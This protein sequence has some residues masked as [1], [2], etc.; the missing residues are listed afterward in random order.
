MKFQLSPGKYQER[1]NN[2]LVLRFHSYVRKRKR[3]LGAVSY[4]HL[5]VY[6][7]QAYLRDGKSNKVS[8]IV[9]L[10]GETYQT[11]VKLGL[12]KAPVTCLLYT[13]ML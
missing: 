11:S 9:E 1:Q 5:D 6:K 3:M 7:R 4:T 10:Y 13:S 12:S 2:I 8:N